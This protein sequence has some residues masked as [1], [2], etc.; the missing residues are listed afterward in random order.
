MKMRLIIWVPFALL[1]AIAIV[2]IYG[3]SGQKEDFVRSHM[4]G[5]K[6]PAFSLPA[7]LPGG[8]GIN[9][10]ALTKGQPIL[11]NFFA[12]WCI[13]CRAEAPHLLALQ[14]AGVKI[15][16]IAVRDKP[17]D[18]SSFLTEGGNPFSVIAAGDESTQLL[19][20]SSAVPES[21]VISGDGRVTYQHIGD[22]RADDVALILSKL[23]EAK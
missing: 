6:L 4:V 15:V 1:A 11:V 17:E 16:G 5:Q 18:I 22:V 20:G 10:A 3:L 12:S 8:Q 14:K 9:D 19:F 7:A 13:P 23:N 21:F 2:A